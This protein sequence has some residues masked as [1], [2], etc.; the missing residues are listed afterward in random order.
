MQ[1]QK[2]SSLRPRI[3][4]SRSR[5]NALSVRRFDRSWPTCPSRGT[6]PSSQGQVGTAQMMSSTS[7]STSTS[8]SAHA[9]PPSASLLRAIAHRKVIWHLCG[10]FVVRID[11]TTMVKFG[12]NLET[13]EAVTMEHVQRLVLHLKIPQPRG[14]ASIGSFSYIFMSFIEGTSLD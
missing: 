11:K 6:S 1:R 13:N 2:M 12:T 4:P 14:V 10:K 7:T 3:P 5:V 9:Q 8:T